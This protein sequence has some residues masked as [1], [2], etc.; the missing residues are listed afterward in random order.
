MATF[1]RLVN[2]GIEELVGV[3]EDTPTE[4]LFELCSNGEIS[5][6]N[7]VF[8]DTTR[9]KNNVDSGWR[10]AAFLCKKRLGT[11]LGPSKPGVNPNTRNQVCVWVWT[12]NVKAVQRWFE[13]EEKRR[14]KEENED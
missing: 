8:T 10:F 12:P 13:A 2:C 4:I 6:R 9:H 3:S 7:V 14:D 1:Y 11:V 5:S